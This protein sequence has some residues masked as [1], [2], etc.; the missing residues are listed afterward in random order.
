M[1]QLVLPVT[2]PIRA[3]VHSA[4][5]TALDDAVKTERALE[6]L[7]LQLKPFPFQWLLSLPLFE[8]MARSADGSTL[9]KIFSGDA[10]VNPS[11][12]L[13]PI[14]PTPRPP[15][16]RGAH[17]AVMDSRYSTPKAATCSREQ[18][19]SSLD[20]SALRWH[21]VERRVRLLH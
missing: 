20:M 1:R 8:T 5:A 10:E 7:V 15:R 16:R 14:A 4:L 3:L 9:L 13:T 12:T 17:A 11:H 19:S 21:V 2:G 6:P 18:A